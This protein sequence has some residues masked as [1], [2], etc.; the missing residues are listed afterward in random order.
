[1]KY[2]SL[3]MHNQHNNHSHIFLVVGILNEIKYHT[4]YMHYQHNKH[5]HNATKHISEHSH[6]HSLNVTLHWF[7]NTIMSTHVIYHLPWQ[8]WGLNQFLHTSPCHLLNTCFIILTFYSLAQ[9]QHQEYTITLITNPSSVLEG[10]PL[11]A[12]WSLR[13]PSLLLWW[14]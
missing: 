4:L 5:S 8:V 12:Q 9:T 6:W 3:Y 7:K 13:E 2:H 10:F 1:M 11:S 14:S